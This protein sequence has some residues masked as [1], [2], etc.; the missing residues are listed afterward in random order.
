MATVAQQLAEAQAAYHELVMGR[1]ARVVVD[2]NGERVEFVA[3]NRQALY[4]Y[5]QSLQAQVAVPVSVP[6]NSPA[7][8]MF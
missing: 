7:G 3:A 1:A 8:F 6:V 5:V 4:L 2:Q